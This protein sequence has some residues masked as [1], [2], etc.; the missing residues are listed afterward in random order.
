LADAKTPM[1]RIL[2]ILVFITGY[3]FSQGICTIDGQT[4]TPSSLPLHTY[5]F[6]SDTTEELTTNT[7]ISLTY[8]SIYYADV[9]TY[10]K[11]CISMYI[12]KAGLRD[13]KYDVGYKVEEIVIDEK[14]KIKAYMLQVYTSIN[15]NAFITKQGSKK[16]GWSYVNGNIVTMICPDKA[17]ADYLA[18]EIDK[19]VNWK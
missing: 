9:L 18:A 7:Y 11:E 15:H 2:I 17:S 8:D 5:P 4:F 13:L 12:V 10:K 6:P 19:R 3:S 1:K 14:K 16:F